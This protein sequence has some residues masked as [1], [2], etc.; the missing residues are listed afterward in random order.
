MR[1]VN[2]LETESRVPWIH[3]KFMADLVQAFG[4][5]PGPCPGGQNAFDITTGE[6]VPS[7]LAPKNAM[8]AATVAGM[9]DIVG[10]EFGDVESLN[11]TRN[12]AEGTRAWGPSLRA[13]AI[14]QIKRTEEL[15][16]AG[17]PLFVK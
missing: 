4:M 11:W 17:S 8:E 16:C 3:V 14:G 15:R 1:A 10:M 2:W 13:S 6:F 7:E 5:M 9:R 12:E